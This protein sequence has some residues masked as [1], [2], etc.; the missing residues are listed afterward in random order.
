METKRAELIGRVV[1]N[2]NDKTIT[3]TVYPVEQGEETK[4]LATSSESP[5]LFYLSKYYAD[6]AMT[7]LE[8]IQ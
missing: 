4:Y 8:Q 1:S 3:V 7:S 5:Y 2:T 6:K